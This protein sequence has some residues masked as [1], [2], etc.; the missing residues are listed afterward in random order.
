MTTV[1]V[2][3]PGLSL[4]EACSTDFG[5]L[6]FDGFGIMLSDEQLQAREEIGPFGPRQHGDVKN[7]WL[8]GGQRA[9]KTVLAFGQHADGCL[10]K[11]G[12]DNTDA[13]YWKNYAYGT[14]AI[15]PIDQLAMRLYAVGSEISKGASDAQWDRGARR[16]RGGAFLSKMRAGKSG[17]WGIWRFSNGSFVDFRSSEG[18]A[19]RLEGGQWWGATWDE[20]AS[21]PDYE[22]E[23]V[24]TDVLLGR[25][26][27]HDAKLLALAWPKAA[28]EHHL[29]K[30]IRD[31]ESG[32]DLDSKVVYLSAEAAYFTNKAALKVERRVKG[33]AQ[34][35]RTV[36]G[37]PAGGAAVEFKTWMI[38]NAKKPVPRQTLPEEG[39][40]YFQSADIGLAHDPTVSFTWRIPIIGGKRIVDPAHKACIVDYFE[41]AGSTGLTL[42]TVTYRITAQQQLYRALTAIDATG[43]G[44]IAAARALDTMRPP[45]MSFVARSNDRLYGNMRLAAITN[46]LDL[47]TWGRI[48]QKEIALHHGDPTWEPPEQDNPWG[49]I[50]FSEDLWELTDQL[51]SFDRDAKSIPDD[52]AWA[53]MIGCW[54]I[55]RLWVVGNPGIRVAHSFDPRS[56]TQTVS[57]RGLRRARLVGV[58]GT[59]SAVVAPSPNGKV[60]VRYSRPGP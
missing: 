7:Y 35:L 15:A 24:A 45:P 43:M 49:C 39:Y 4:A 13:R 8:S 56:G 22:I 6:M 54:Y 58:P 42:D 48:D 50:E 2:P 46:A 21:Q 47:M 18:K 16:S 25:L 60:V 33:E 51:L 57:H 31:I 5:R 10:Y 9:G 28:T 38:A 34:W 20:W 23:D 29:I 17:P 41:L 53:F 3:T 11:R 59:D 44:G 12:V 19:Y 36:L 32:K 27:D 55:R 40:A 30:R 14:L 1:Y 37:K 52:R 26:R